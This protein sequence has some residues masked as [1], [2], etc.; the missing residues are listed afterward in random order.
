MNKKKLK[1][2]YAYEDYCLNA[3]LD[4]D[5]TSTEVRVCAHGYHAKAYTQKMATNIKAWVLGHPDKEPDK[6][7]LTVKVV[8]EKVEC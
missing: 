8:Y 4:G 7:L 5:L 6:V 1:W 3:L 2:K